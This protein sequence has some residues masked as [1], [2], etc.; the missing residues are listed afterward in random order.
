[1][2][3]ANSFFLNTDVFKH[4]EHLFLEDLINSFNTVRH[5]NLWHSKDILDINGILIDEAADTD[6]H[7]LNRN[8]TGCMFE[9]LN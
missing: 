7:H 5:T 4:I 9:H 3:P 8:S 2:E 6:A 1:M